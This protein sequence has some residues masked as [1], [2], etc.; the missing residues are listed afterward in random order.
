MDAPQTDSTVILSATHIASGESVRFELKQKMYQLGRATAE[1]EEGKLSVGFDPRL[2]RRLALLQV[3][4]GAV[5]VKRDQSRYPLFHEGTERDSF[6]LLPGQRFSSGETVFELVD[7]SARTLTVALMEEVNRENADQILEV[8]LKFQPLLQSWLEPTELAARSVRLL[9]QLLP[10]AE[11]AVFQRTD[12]GR[13]NPLSHSHLIPSRSLVSECLSQQAPTYHIWR[14]GL[15]QTLAQPTRQEGESWAFAAPVSASEFSYFLYA[16]GQQSAEA[17]GE[18]RRSA[19]ALVAQLLAQHLEGRKVAV[20]AA[21]VEAEALT[22]QRLRLLLETIERSMALEQDG[23]FQK[24][25][26]NVARQLTGAE[27]AYFELDLSR[28]LAKGS[29]SGH[30]SDSEGPFLA[31][32]FERSWPE[33]IVCRKESDTLFSGEQQSWLEALAVFCETVF[34]NRRLHN[35][36]KTSLEQL[37]TT[38]SVLIQS[39]Q[40]AA[41]GRLAANGAHELNTPLGAIKLS[42]ETALTF[43]KDAPKPAQEGLELILRSVERCRKVTDRFLQYSR[44]RKQAL[45]EDF[46]LAPILKDS[47]DSVAPLLESHNITL[48]TQAESETRVAGD[49]QDCYWALTN[50]LKNAVDALVDNNCEIRTIA[51]EGHQSDGRLVLSISDSG[52]GI[53]PEFRSKIFEPFFS[54]KKIGHGNGL[55]LSTSRRQLRVWGGDLILTESTRGA[56]FQIFLPLAE[57]SS[58]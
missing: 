7:G 56:C 51:I 40:W 54:T 23:S 14:S 26:L 21:R 19:L 10:G 5:E 18:L 6:L 33:G 43:L 42:A 13:L 35:Q 17:P 52:P 31:A 30:G 47:V 44:P 58:G 3:K 45:T 20:L 57:E 8:V 49:T 39:R 28:I 16:V 2:S 11:V 1:D 15:D 29:R 34:E 9:S 25:Y 22:N 12:D 48:K 37:K 41:A 46:L 32:A 53:A 4:A 24:L 27:I 38:Q 55:G 50:I 36:V